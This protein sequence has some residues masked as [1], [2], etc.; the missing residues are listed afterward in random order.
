MIDDIPY[1]D[2]EP[3]KLGPPV[4]LDDVI[5]VLKYLV[6]ECA[7][8]REYSTDDIAH[9]LTCEELV[10]FTNSSDALN[11]ENEAEL[12]ERTK[13]KPIAVAYVLSAFE[14]PYTAMRVLYPI[15]PLLVTPE[16]PLS[17]RPI[18]MALECGIVFENEQVCKLKMQS[19][20]GEKPTHQPTT[21]LVTTMLR[22]QCDNAIAIMRKSGLDKL[23]EENATKIEG[24]AQMVA[25]TLALARQM[26]KA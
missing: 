9:K 20:L 21:G 4:D 24:A 13:I 11:S 18:Y 19:F 22:H 23:R 10:N 14:N 5:V 12:I 3:E 6:R 15:W 2:P 1:K 26:G 17:V 25:D 8:E 16:P 7:S